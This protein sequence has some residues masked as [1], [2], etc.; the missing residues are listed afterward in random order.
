MLVSCHVTSHIGFLISIIV[1][2]HSVKIFSDFHRKM[3]IGL[4]ITRQAASPYLPPTWSL[5]AGE[6]CPSNWLRN[7]AYTKWKINGWF[8]W[9]YELLAPLE[10]RDD[11]SSSKS[12]HIFRFE[13]LIFRGVCR[14][15][16]IN[17]LGKVKSIWI[18]TATV[19][20][21][22]DVREL[23]W[24]DSPTV[25]F[26]IQSGKI[27]IL[28]YPSP[29]VNPHLMQ[30]PNSDYCCKL[31]NPTGILYHSQTKKKNYTPN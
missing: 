2:P 20:V 21:N 22:N 1:V 16:T 8:T 25:A 17:F 9:E 10:F 31:L 3:S 7:E 12:L 23:F 15:P 4:W 29:D 5:H 19:E 27:Y 24:E 14:I 6:V 26:T 18:G 30:N 13:L 11:F 28:F